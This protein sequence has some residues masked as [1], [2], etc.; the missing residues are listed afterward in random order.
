M[1]KGSNKVSP[2]ND[3]Q[4]SRNIMITL[5]IKVAYERMGGVFTSQWLAFVH[6]V[7]HIF[8][9]DVDPL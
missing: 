3:A 2:E 4:C 1:R 8:F 5:E 6:R 9:S 7:V